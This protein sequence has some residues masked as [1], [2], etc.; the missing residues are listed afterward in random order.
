MARSQKVVYLQEPAGDLVNP[1][2]VLLG[3]AATS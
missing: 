3:A 2:F 1:Y